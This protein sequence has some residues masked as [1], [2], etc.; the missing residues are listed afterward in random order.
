MR[1]VPLE[2]MLVWVCMF[3]GGLAQF[4]AGLM[5]WRSL[6]KHNYTFPKKVWMASSC[7]LNDIR[8]N[9]G[10]QYDRW[11]NLQMIF[12]L[13]F[14]TILLIVTVAKYVRSH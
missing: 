3:V 8:N 4:W 7:N 11:W 12:I 6:S 14:P 5:H 9:L 13:M 10:S 1:E 2:L